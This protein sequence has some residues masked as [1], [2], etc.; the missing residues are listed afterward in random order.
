MEVV[1]ESPPPPPPVQV[2]VVPAPPS[3]EHFW[4]AGYHR[5]DGRAYV[6]VPGRYD[7]RPHAGAVWRPARWE[8]RGRGRVWVEARWE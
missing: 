8:A 7:R 2:E 4:I 5:W 6:W 3:P 1:V